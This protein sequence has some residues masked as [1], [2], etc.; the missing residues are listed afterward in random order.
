[1]AATHV[2]AGAARSMGGT[3]GGIFRQSVGDDGWEHLTNGVPEGAEV[4]AITVHPENPAVVY[5]G[6]TKGTYRS[7][8]RGTRWE[9]LNLP[10]SDADIWSVC[11]HPKNPRTIYAGATPPGVYRSDDGGDTW[12]KMADPGLPDRV[13]MAFACRVL[14]L[15]I[16][17]NSPDDVYATLE[18]N[19]AMR[20]RNR[21]ESW[22]D[23]T[24]DLI[25][26]CEQPKY[27]SRIGS[28]TDIEGMLDGH[29]LACSAAAPGTVFLANRMGL[30]KS[31]DRGQTWIDMEIGKFSPLTY[32]R[33]I[34]TSALDAK[35]MYAAL[36][37]AARSTDGSV[38]RSDDVGQTWKRF[39][40]GIKA[41]ATMMGVIAHPK[42]PD[43]VY[44]VSRVGQ[45]FGTQ[46][47][48]KS[49]SESRLPEGVRDCYA[50]ACG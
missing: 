12:R 7:T 20:S 30:F 13:I 44:G 32:G 5:I 4:H 26:F 14:R 24:A 45:V 25:R 21:G 11:I 9:K 46:D 16:D 36:S 41:D 2:Y 19:G 42:D 1:M 10:D 8:N 17:P 27:K 37:P 39:D 38:Y 15:D 43:Q 35:I 29:A 18:A 33:D 49:W 6:T 47:G 48:G 34:R 28:Q 22:E 31:A 23:C 50:V 40:H 3:L